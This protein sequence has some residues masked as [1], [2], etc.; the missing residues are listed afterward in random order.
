MFYFQTNRL[1]FDAEFLGRVRFVASLASLAGVG[2]FNFAL[3]PVALRKIFLWTSLIGTVL[4]LSQLLLITGAH[5]LSLLCL[6]CGTSANLA[7]PA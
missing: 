5:L 1:G 3:K 2:I 4:G 6:F 7:G